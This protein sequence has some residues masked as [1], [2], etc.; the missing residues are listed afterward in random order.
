MGSTA[1]REIRRVEPGADPGPVGPRRGGGQGRGARPRRRRLPDEAV[2]RGGAVGAGSRAAAPGGAR[3]DA[4]RGSWTSDRDRSTL[5]R[6][7]RRRARA[8]VHLTPTE[9]RLLEA[10]ASRPG[11]LR[12]H[13]WLLGHVWDA[14]ERARRRGAAGVRQPAPRASSRPIRGD[15][16]VIA[17]EPGRRVSLAARAGGV[18]GQSADDRGAERVA[19]RRTAGE[20]DE[21]VA[22]PNTVSGCGITTC[23]SRRIATIAESFGSRSS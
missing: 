9:W 8:Q 20:R 17:T 21:L 18:G 23:P 14:G 15:P 5:G 6:A 1:C 11:V 13:D 2:R 10:L 16:R 7:Q 12:T 19:R 3:A 4:A 22:R